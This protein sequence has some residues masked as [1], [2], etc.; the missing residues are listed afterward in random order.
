MQQNQIH[1]LQALQLL[2]DLHWKLSHGLRWRRRQAQPRH[3]NASIW[4]GGLHHAETAYVGHLW[5]LK[6]VV[7]RSSTVLLCDEDSSSVRRQVGLFQFICIKGH[8]ECVRFIRSSSVPLLLLGGCG[9]TI[10]NVARCCCYEACNKL[11]TE[12]PSCEKHICN[13]SSFVWLFVIIVLIPVTL[14]K[15]LHCLC[16][17]NKSLPN[18]TTE[19]P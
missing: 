11:T 9:Y 12:F 1:T 14:M 19:D 15:L 13:A 4:A 5:T 16:S 6:E 2:P 8:A 3:D 10:T 7:W 18:V 17:T